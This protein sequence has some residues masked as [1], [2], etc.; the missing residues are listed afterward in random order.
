[1]VRIYETYEIVTPESAEHGD[2]D[3]RGFIIPG[4]LPVTDK[5]AAPTAYTFRELIKVL[6]GTQAS[7][8]GEKRFHDWA[9]C[10]EWRKDFRTGAIESRSYHPATPKDARW[11]WKAHAYATRRRAH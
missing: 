3:E 7:T 9:T 8:T 10:E 2:A 5:P 11:F 1:M 4:N 6:E